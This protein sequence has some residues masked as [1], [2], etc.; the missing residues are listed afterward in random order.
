MPTYV[1]SIQRRVRVYIGLN[2]QRVPA[3]AISGGREKKKKKRMSLPRIHDGIIIDDIGRVPR[4]ELIP[5]IA[6]VGVSHIGGDIKGMRAKSIVTH[7]LIVGQRNPIALSKRSRV[8][9]CGLKV[10]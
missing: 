10:P 4:R 8:G 2:A 5:T 7:L 1:I 3:I 6:G 9:G